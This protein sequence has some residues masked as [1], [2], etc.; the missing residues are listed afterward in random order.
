MVLKS[1]SS[2]KKVFS[3]I[4]ISICFIAVIAFA[5]INTVQVTNTQKELATTQNGLTDTQSELAGTQAELLNTEATLATTTNAL[6][7]TRADLATA[8]AD[9]S[10]TRNELQTTS[11]KLTDTTSQLAQT[12]ADYTTKLKALDTETTLTGTLQS[13]FDSL[14]TDY[15][16]AT[17]GYAYA[18]R[19][20]S[21]Q[22]LETFLLA[23]TTDAN[24]YL[25]GSYVCEDFSFDVK[26]HAMQQKFRCAFVYLVFVGENHAIIAFNTTDRGIVYIEPQTDEEVNLQA[27]KHY[28][29]QC[30]IPAPG[31]TH[32]NPTDYDDTVARFSLIW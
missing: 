10:S 22:E 26:T 25:L 8:Q 24:T 1:T 32:S 21:H 14:H 7:Q 23:D 9:L 29:T 30:V 17:A 3:N 15:N 2:G 20:P 16:S 28:W 6:L 27:G 13:S 18:Y 11:K 4:F 31:N 19:D 5:A 12:Q